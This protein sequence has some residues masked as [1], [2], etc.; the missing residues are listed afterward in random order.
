MF[1]NIIDYI[2]GLGAAIFFTDYNDYNW[3]DI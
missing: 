3:F 2:L 1:Q